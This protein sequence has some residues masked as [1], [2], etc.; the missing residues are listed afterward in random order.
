MVET[1]RNYR[2]FVPLLPLFIFQVRFILDIIEVSF[3]SMFHILVKQAS[4][5]QDRLSEASELD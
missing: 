2:F 3:S 1:N 5:S 4:E